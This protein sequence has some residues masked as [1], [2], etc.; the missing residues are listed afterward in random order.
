[1]CVNL[2]DTALPPLWIIPGLF[3]TALPPLTGDHLFIPCL[4]NP[5]IVCQTLLS[6]FLIMWL[7]LWLALCGSEHVPLSGNHPHDTWAWSS[8]S[9]A[10]IPICFL[11]FR[12]WRPLPPILPMLHHDESTHSVLMAS[13]STFW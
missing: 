6:C 13:V 12:C 10:I 8:S 11:S 5:L 2:F 7:P 9:H 3:N 4:V 1:M